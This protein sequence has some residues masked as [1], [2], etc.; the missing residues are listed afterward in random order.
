MRKVVNSIVAALVL[1]SPASAQEMTLLFHNGSRTIYTRDKGRVEIRYETPK[2]GLSVKEGTLL[3]S[4]VSDSRGNYSG[5]A[6]TFKSGCEPAPYPV[7]GKESGPGIVLVGVAPRRASHS[8]AIIGDTV[9]GK[10][11][12]LVFEYEAEQ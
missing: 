5:T 3:F 9:T 7:A 11:A 8:C 6:Y 4:G 1:S 12:R 10:N 2:A